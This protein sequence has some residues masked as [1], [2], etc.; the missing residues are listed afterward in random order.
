MRHGEQS[1]YLFILFLFILFY[2]YLFYF[3]PLATNFFEMDNIMYIK[4][5]LEKKK[6]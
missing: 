4:Y 3:F 5:S 6:L 2:F 1:I